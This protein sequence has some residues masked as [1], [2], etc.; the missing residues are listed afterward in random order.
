MGFELDEIIYKKGDVISA[1]EQYINPIPFH[2]YKTL[3][4]LLEDYYSGFLDDE[5]I[6]NIIIKIM[7]LLINAYF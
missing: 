7:F 3:T 2:Y 4:E 6:I 1:D 5:V